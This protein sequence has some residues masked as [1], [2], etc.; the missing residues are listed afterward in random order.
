MKMK[1]GMESTLPYSK[2]ILGRVLCAGHLGVV[3]NDCETIC[4]LRF[5]LLR[6][7]DYRQFSAW[8]HH[9]ESLPLAWFRE[10]AKPTLRTTMI[11]YWIKIIY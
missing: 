10:F 1:L 8:G 9:Y 3:W 2:L 7:A 6:F 4:E 5:R 11:V